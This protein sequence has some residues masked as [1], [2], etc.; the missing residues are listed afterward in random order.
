MLARNSFS[1]IVI[2][3]MVGG[4]LSLS[5]LGMAGGVF[6]TAGTAEAA[7]VSK[8]GDLSTFRTIVV[9]VKTLT[10]KGDLAAAKTRVKDLEIAW[11]EAEAGL[12][13]RAASDWHTIDKAIDRAL[14]ALRSSS[15]DGATCKQAMA[16]LLE[17]MD[18][19]NGGS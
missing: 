4:A 5:G 14:E 6:G 18:K 15:P 9:D 3:T 13:P 19:M 11:D 8:L 10:D 16:A 1:A 7:L 2:R 12:K 17:T